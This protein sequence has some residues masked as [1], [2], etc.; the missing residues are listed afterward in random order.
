M[1]WAD[2]QPRVQALIR[3]WQ[4]QLDLQD[5]YIF[6]EFHPEID[7]DTYAK[8]EMK[9]SGQDS[10]C[11]RLSIGPAFFELP[12]E[13]MASVVLHELIHVLL[14]PLSDALT[15]TYSQFTTTQQELID[16]LVLHGDEASTYRL[17]RILTKH[18]HPLAE[19][20]TDIACDVNVRPKRKKQLRRRSLPNTK[21]G[22]GFHADPDE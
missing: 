7:A 19:L 22:I 16:G 10:H 8:V 18:V 9:G 5:L 17:E 13:E 4:V 15:P 3:F 12:P 1:T 11:V 21:R 20:L 2:V 6:L 14:W